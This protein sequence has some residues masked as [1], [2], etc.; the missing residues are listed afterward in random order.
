M[1]LMAASFSL[2]FVVLLLLCIQRAP[3]HS[4]FVLP[5]RHRCRAVSDAAARE[6]AAVLPVFVMALQCVPFVMPDHWADGRSFDELLGYTTHIEAPIRQVRACQ[7][8]CGSHVHV[9]VLRVE[10]SWSCGGCGKSG[11][12][13][14]HEDASDSVLRCHFVFPSSKAL[15]VIERRGSLSTQTL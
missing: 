11:G 9:V 4:F 14:P 3:I 8:A 12:L 10:S 15:R 1:L 7:C 5:P 6:R 2:R 13:S